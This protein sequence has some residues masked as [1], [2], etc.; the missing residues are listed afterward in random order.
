MSAKKSLNLKPLE[1]RRNPY[2][3]RDLAQEYVKP[4]DGKRNAMLRSAST[5]NL[6]VNVEP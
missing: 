6:H 3:G 2:R 1:D 5:G 4:R